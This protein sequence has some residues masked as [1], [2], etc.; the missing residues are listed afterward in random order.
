MRPFEGQEKQQTRKLSATS[1][2]TASGDI[3]TS[4]SSAEIFP[5][6]LS[7]G[8]QPSSPLSDTGKTGAVGISVPPSSS[9]LERDVVP[10]HA[11]CST[12]AT[13]LGSA[14]LGVEDA[15]VDAGL[16]IAAMP[17]P[18]L[19]PSSPASK[20]ASVNGG[21][22]TSTT[23]HG[24][25]DFGDD[26]SSFAITAA[27]PT[28]PRLPGRAIARRNGWSVPLG[29]HR[30]V[31]APPGLRVTTQAHR[32]SAPV[33]VPRHVVVAKSDRSNTIAYRWRTKENG[34][35]ESVLVREEAA[36]LRAGA[37]VEVLETQ[38][39]GE[40]V[41]GRICWEVAEDNEEVLDESGTGSNGNGDDTH[42]SK[43]RTPKTPTSMRQLKSKIPTFK[44]P[45]NNHKSLEEADNLKGCTKQKSEQQFIR[46][47][48]GWIS[49]QWVKADEHSRRMETNAIGGQKS[50][51][52]TE[53]GGH[54][55]SVYARADGDVAT[56]EDAGPWVRSS[57][58]HVLPVLFVC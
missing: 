12:S 33:V 47:Y 7:A 2:G 39:H 3:D 50:R 35:L 24:R 14:D 51:L 46:R 40:R 44:K 9:A 1:C 15:G 41:R 49:L 36:V 53:Y 43:K 30:M 34:E 27:P 17:S 58:S 5:E 10:G 13:D 31:C 22:S 6:T 56:D 48:E 32:R 57:P 19:L 54:G 45:H 52:G 28:A 11:G 38:V 23:D 29:V 55:M 26:D 8:G 25:A 21:C 16:A 42:I 4:L 20:Q 18:P 37:Y